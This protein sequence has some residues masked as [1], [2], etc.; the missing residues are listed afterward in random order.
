MASAHLPF[1]P[2]LRFVLNRVRHLPVAGNEALMR[3]LSIGDVMAY[4]AAENKQ[5]VHYLTEYLYG[6]H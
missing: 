4:H 1:S 6:Q 3:K 5:M 2:V